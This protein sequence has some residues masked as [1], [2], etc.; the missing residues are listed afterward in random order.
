MSVDQTQQF[1]QKMIVVTPLF[2]VK[3][4]EKHPK[5]MQILGFLI[6]KFD[7]YAHLNGYI[8]I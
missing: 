6:H 2:F 4:Y 8:K 7:E 3:K 1:L 5:S